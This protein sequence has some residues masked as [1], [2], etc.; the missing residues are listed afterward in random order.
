M[1]LANQ[2]RFVNLAALQN[3]LTDSPQDRRQL[4]QSYFFILALIFEGWSLVRRLGQDFHQREAFRNGFAPLL[5]DRRI[6]DF[7]E[8]SMKRVR[9]SAM[10]HPDEDEIARCLGEIVNPSEVLISGVKTWS[11][12]N[13]YELADS[14]LFATLVGPCASQAEFMAKYR[15]AMETSREILGK[16][17]HAADQLIV[18]VLR[19]EKPHFEL[20]SGFREAIMVGKRWRP[21]SAVSGGC[22]SG[23]L[24]GA[25][26]LPSGVGSGSEHDCSRM[27]HLPRY[28]RPPKGSR[29]PVCGSPWG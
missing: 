13:Y 3:D 14:L 1:R 22:P 10:F 6:K 16:F 9:N 21:P 27:E 17:L 4:N 20:V 8:G 26:Q 18:E 7:V 19:D 28:R 25:D 2:I 24:S 23:C 29:L 5:A 12:T 15:A 11:S